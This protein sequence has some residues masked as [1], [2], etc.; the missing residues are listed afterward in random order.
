MQ[1]SSE[2]VVFYSSQLLPLNMLKIVITLRIIVYI[3]SPEY[4]RA[5]AAHVRG[6]DTLLELNSNGKIKRV[7]NER[8]SISENKYFIF[9]YMLSDTA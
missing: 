3:L 4:V 5:E 6:A 7:N 8:S 1:I 2:G 9:H